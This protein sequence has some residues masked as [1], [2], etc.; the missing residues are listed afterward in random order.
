MENTV[1]NVIELLDSN[2]YSSS[3]YKD[4]IVA[5][6][7]EIEERGNNFTFSIMDKVGGTLV[8][9]DCNGQVIHGEFYEFS[10]FN[11]V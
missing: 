2:S 9:L 6:I 4:W 1:D 5:R 11:L 10:K 8:E 3:F 7:D